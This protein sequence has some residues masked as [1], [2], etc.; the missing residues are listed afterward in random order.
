M[1]RAIPVGLTLSFIFLAIIV[2][3]YG[4]HDD[5]M[6]LIVYFYNPFTYLAFPRP[7]ALIL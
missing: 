1:T 7:E 3:V 4:F 6:G 5:Y 2:I